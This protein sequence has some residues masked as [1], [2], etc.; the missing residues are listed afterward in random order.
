MQQDQH[1][2]FV[3]LTPA[4]SVSFINFLDLSKERPSA[5]QGTIKVQA[6]CDH[7]DQT[8]S[9]V[10]FMGCCLE[11]PNNQHQNR[12]L[13][14]Q[15]SSK[16]ISEWLVSHNFMTVGLHRLAAMEPIVH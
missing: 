11:T 5:H 10:G 12:C 2:L 4:S 14:R 3:E 16:N 6:K 9:Y 7:V 15:K 13:R 1:D 8:F